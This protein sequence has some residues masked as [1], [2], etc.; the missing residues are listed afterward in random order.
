MST[1]PDSRFQAAGTA[2]PVIFRERRRENRRPV[3]GKA[4]LVVMDGAGAGSVHEIQTRD[5]SLSGIS[6]LLRDCLSVGQT[7]R[8]T[9]FN[10]G[11][12]C[13]HICEVVRSRML[14]NGRYEMAVQF[15]KTIDE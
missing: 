12:S 10:A 2:A 9:I 3:P 13:T 14:S 8:I 5:L 1:L 6:F 15:R 4:T 7:C 11:G